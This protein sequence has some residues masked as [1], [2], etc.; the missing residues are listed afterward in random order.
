MVLC[1]ETYEIIIIDNHYAFYE[2]CYLYFLIYILIVVPV[3]GIYYSSDGGATW[4]QATGAPI[5]TGM[6]IYALAASASGQIMAAAVYSG[7]ISFPIHQQKTFSLY[8]KIT[9]E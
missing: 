5:G 4:L 1:I 2:F 3:N 8:K 6:Y 9:I 7:R